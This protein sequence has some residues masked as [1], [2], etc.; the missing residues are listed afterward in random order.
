MEKLKPIEG[1]EFLEEKHYYRVRGTF[2]PSVSSIIRPISSQIYGDIDEA[3]LDKAKA[4]GTEVHLAVEIYDDTGA[5]VISEEYKGYLDAYKSFR[6]DNPNLEVVATE[7]RVY[8]PVLWYAGT[9]D[10]VYFNTMTQELILVDFKSS[11]GIECATLIP[12]LTG[13]EKALKAH[14]IN[15]KEIYV[16]HVKSDGTYKYE[17]IKMDLNVFVA[18][19]TLNNHIKKYKKR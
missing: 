16:L 1:I 9:V 2:I 5:D 6:K 19:M 8:D 11:Y 10:K 14:G 15:V 4:R 3:I 7:Y 17:P 18:C 12:Q 13:Y